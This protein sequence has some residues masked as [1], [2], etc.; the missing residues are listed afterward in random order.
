MY[1]DSLGVWVVEV[2][3]RYGTRMDD[4]PR[5]LPEAAR[6]VHAQTADVLIGHAELHGHEEYIVVRKIRLVVRDNSLDDA[7]LQKPTDAAAIHRIAR[8]AVYLPTH[9]A[10]RV[11]ALDTFQHVLKNGTSRHLRA[12]L[13]NKF[14]RN[15]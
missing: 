13:F 11:A 14:F 4:L 8:E 3:Q 12:P 7:L 2:A 10:L 1:D 6:Q 15:L 9:D 5:F